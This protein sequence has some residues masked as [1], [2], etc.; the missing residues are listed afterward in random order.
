M[1]TGEV[2]ESGI[3]TVLGIVTTDETGNETITVF[4]TLTITL[5]GTVFG[6][7]DH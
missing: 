4:G 1:A 2:Y 3:V 6:N 5:V 7:E